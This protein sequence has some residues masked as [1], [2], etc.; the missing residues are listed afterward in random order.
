MDGVPELPFGTSS[1]T[2]GAPMNM[3]AV[4]SMRI[5]P[6]IAV[7]CPVQNCGQEP[8][9]SVA[10]SQVLRYGPRTAS[11]AAGGLMGSVVPPA[12]VEAGAAVPASAADGASAPLPASAMPPPATA[13]PEYRRKS[14]RRGGPCVAAASS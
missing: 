5:R 9:S 12:G 4:P 3:Y 1:G 14:R 8:G 11:G 13:A 7:M 2:A 6:A 10:G